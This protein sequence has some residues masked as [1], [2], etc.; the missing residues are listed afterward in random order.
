V[1]WI[2]TLKPMSDFTVS[3]HGRMKMLAS[4]TLLSIAPALLIELVIAAARTMLD[5]H[6][7]GLLAETMSGITWS[8]LVCFGVAAGSAL[9]RV[10][11][12]AAGAI[13]F[14]AT[15]IA[16]FAARAVQGGLNEFLDQ[17]SSTLPP[18]FALIAAAKACEYGGLAYVL[19]RLAH[20]GIDS[21]GPHLLAGLAVAASFGTI[22]VAIVAKAPDP[23]L[24][25]P[26]L[27]AP[28]INEL[29]FPLGCV[30]AVF[31]TRTAYPLTPGS[32]HAS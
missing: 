24:A 22:I 21:M 20:A 27:T 5:I 25:A 4:L 29:L 3:A 15:P 2:T 31:L 30:L 19:A 11:E 6:A 16:L 13:A 1:F 10:S 18:G 28:A 23:D 17:S 7:Q 12:V 32:G 26:A 14:I 8:L 9:S